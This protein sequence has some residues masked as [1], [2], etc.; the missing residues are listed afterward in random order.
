MITKYYSK[1]QLAVTAGV[2]RTTFYRWML[3]DQPVLEQMGVRP[4][5]RLMNPK[6]VEFICQKHHIDMT[7]LP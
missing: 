6:A 4:S 7:K 2:S 5:Q 1:K 3:I